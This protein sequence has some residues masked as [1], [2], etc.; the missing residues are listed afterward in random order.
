MSEPANIPGEPSNFIG[1][2]TSVNMS[3]SG[4]SATKEVTATYTMPDGS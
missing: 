1:K 4:N 3:V 2:S